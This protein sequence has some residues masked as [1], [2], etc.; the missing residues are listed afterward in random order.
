MATWVV[1][2]PEDGQVQGFYER[3]LVGAHWAGVRNLADVTTRNELQGLVDAEYGR[4]SPGAR[5]GITEQ[6]YAFRVEMT[7][8]DGV[9]TYHRPTR[10]YHVGVVLGDY[11][12]SLRASGSAPHTRAVQWQGQVHRDDLSADTRLKLGQ[13]REV[14]KV[15]DSVWDELLE[16]RTTG[17]AAARAY[18]DETLE[19]ARVET[20]E[21]MRDVLADRLAALLPSE[22]E[23]LVMGLLE[24]TG[25]HSVGPAIGLGAT[26]CLVASP[27]GLGLD[28]PRVRVHIEEPRRAPLDPTSA[29]AFLA[30]LRPGEKGLLVCTG[31]FAPEARRE[32]ERSPTA[33]T[34]ADLELLVQLVLRHYETLRPDVRAMLPL[35]RFY[36]PS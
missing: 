35:A 11:V 13:H 10:Q 20:E 31:G 16:V 21:R 22:L 30:A 4:E 26:R 1:R 8:G 33:V 29:R 9:V 19:E 17:P 27:G 12:Y 34:L 15:R 25:L 18:D 7:I 36:W 6:L 32:T 14:F 2:C 28:E 5:F 23:R 3:G 24:A